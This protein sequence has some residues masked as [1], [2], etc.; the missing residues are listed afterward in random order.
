MSEPTADEQPAG[1]A[2]DAHPDDRDP[3]PDDRDPRP[4]DRDPHPDARD[5]RDEARVDEEIDVVAALT[6]VEAADA[7]LRSRLR[8]RLGVGGT[9]LVVLQFIARAEAVRRPVRVKDL[10]QHVGMTSAATSVIL[11]RLEARGHVLRDVDPADR[12]SKL[13]CLSDDTRDAMQEAVGSTQDAL[14]V[15]LDM[16]GHRDRKRLVRLLDR[17]VAALELGVPPH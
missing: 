16:V 3:R 2:R 4:D 14:R 9:D 11:D 15:V 1:D 5:A 13:I 6:R 8:A 17:V 12:R 7:A 10:T